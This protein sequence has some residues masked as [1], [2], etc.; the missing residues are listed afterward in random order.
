[1]PMR[2]TTKAWFGPKRHL[3]WG[4]SPTSW[5]GYA[6]TVVFLALSRR[7]ALRQRS[8]VIPTLVLLGVFFLVVLLT[9][10]PPGGVAAR[11]RTLSGWL[12]AVR[13]PR[14]GRRSGGPGG[15]G[16]HLRTYAPSRDPR[17]GT[18]GSDPPA[19][20]RRVHAGG[21]LMNWSV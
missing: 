10:D 7:M 8:S 15:R 16:A 11:A 14:H 6:A 18:D 4:W 9:G 21:R 12:Y 19:R 3:G 13:Q 1:M 17:A 2:L 20:P 5:E